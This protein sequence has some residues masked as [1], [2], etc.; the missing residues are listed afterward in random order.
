MVALVLRLRAA[1]LLGAWR[2]GRARAVGGLLAAV[3]LAAAAVA[4]LLTL[5][6]AP[7]A[8]ARIVLAIGGSA[9][10]TGFLLVPLLTRTADPLDPRRFIVTGASWPAVAGAVLAASPVSIPV[11]ALIA[12]AV[13]LARA[14]TA[15]GAD[16]TGSAF[17][18][19]LL[20]VTHVLWARVALA[21]A[22]LGLAERR[23]RELS[24]LLLLGAIVVAVPVA[25][26]FAS[27][28]WGAGLPAP[29]QSVAAVLAVTPLGAAWVLPLAPSLLTVV[30]AVA[31]PLVLAAAWLFLVR[32]ML[33]RPERPVSIRE[34]RGLGWFTVTPGTPGGAVAARS[35][36][37][38]LRDPRHLVDVVIIPIA[39]AVTVIP[40][41]IVGVPLETV[42]LIP[43]PL[44]ALLLGWLAHNDLAYDGSA[45]WLHV[46]SGMRGASDR[47]GRLVPLLLVALPLLAVAIPVGASM[48]GDWSVL[49]A[50]SGV[51]AA[52]LLGGLGLSSIASVVSPYAVARHG[53]SP[54]Q[55]P[56]RAGGGF[57]QGVV[58]VGALAFSAPAF[59]E[60]WRYLQGVPDAQWW[61][62]GAGT[63][64]GVVVLGLGILLGGAI[65]D[66]RGDRVMAFAETT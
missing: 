20:V 18:A 57:S 62:L 6:D 61:A 8:A 29:L 11:L 34:R 46:S 47:A 27:L 4:A 28:E 63:A 38:W 16:A 36:I 41:L 1:L 5:G 45:V 60:G 15:Q 25:V 54:F 50:L 49:P 64:V 48:H 19:V 59:W 13:A 52:L 51:C 2:T 44:I 21:V 56:Q 39:A 33:T 10:S 12:V 3:I 55:Q 37:Y 43:A 7:P 40:L 9:I 17:A 58:L 14:W 42:A 31:T 23:S 30:V 66:R 53:D 22:A 35:L 24:S 26:F 65:F 32:R